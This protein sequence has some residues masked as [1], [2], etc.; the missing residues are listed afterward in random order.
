MEVRHEIIEFDRSC[1]LKL[2]MHKLGDVSRH[3]H[4]SIE[5]LFVLAGEVTVLAGGRQT[6]LTK[7]DVLL[8]N[9]NTAHEL[10]AD[11]CVIIALQI[12]LSKFDL[13]EKLLRELY[14]DC[15]STTASGT[16]DFSRL[17][18]L[19]ANMIQR[20]AAKNDTTIL[21]NRAMAYSLLHE[22]M[23]NFGAE[24][25]AGDPYAR[26]HLER[27]N[28]IIHYIN[29]HYQEQLTLNQ[30]AE[31]QHL[32][33][34]YLSSFFDKY[35]GVNF[36]TYYTNLRLDH[37]MQNLIDSDVP[38]EQ[39]AVNNGFADARAFVRAFKK[40]YGI[41]PSVYRRNI[42]PTT[43]QTEK[44]PLLAINYLDF[45]PENYLHVLSQYMEN[46]VRGSAAAPQREATSLDLGEISAA[47]PVRARLRHKWRTFIG[48]GRARELLYADV[49]QML[50]Q[51]QRDIGFRY[52]RFH[53]IF[54]DDM[55][56]CKKEK[57]GVLRF[58][59]T[60]IDKV[61]DFIR[62]VGLRP[63]IQFS[64]MPR[65]LAENPSHQ[66]YDSPFIIS[67][68]AR[69][70]E[71]K[72]LVRSFLEHVRARYGAAEMRNWLFS[73]WNEPDT[74]TYLFG[75]GTP[76][77]YYALYEATYRT[78]KEFDPVLIFGTPSLFPI[79]DESL[80]WVRNYLD[81]ARRSQC[82][83]QFLDVHYYSDNFRT[84]N[85]QNA[86][87]TAPTSLSGDPEHFGKFLSTIRSFLASELPEA[88]PLYVTEW[89][90]TVSHRN[91][92]NDT[93]F[94]A[95]YL[96]KNFLEN[97]D[98]ADAV[99]YWSLT[100]FLEE[101]QLEEELFHGGMGLFTWNG[102]KKPP[103]HA[104]V[105]LARLGSQLVASGAGYFITREGQEYRAVLYNYEHC[106]PLFT[107]EGFGLTRT[108]RDGVFPLRRYLDV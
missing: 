32:S 30:L 100:D 48:V 94:K 64:F 33:T 5:L 3:W 39:L 78:V 65:A 77:R 62:S 89:N 27:L 19:I 90:L 37:A 28:S 97:Y 60:L 69:M 34:P 101:S 45:K 56:V 75:L 9:S 99:G 31:Q 76:E 15:D 71:W 41:I 84:V 10:H 98:R 68:P 21:S 104:M 92:I 91:L 59:F 43:A 87:F 18:Q 53:G 17:K 44:D 38:V 22:L 79:S 47:A 24:K 50:T 83:P 105:M 63:L 103:Y 52:V 20:N 1:P 2:F 95:C 36:S 7:D 74:S 11:E 8:I 42:A 66:V 51:L 16:K 80:A 58:S 25:P 106:N 96:A 13:P 40:K 82:V 81:F 86:A 55:L 29:A 93:C 70:D 35:M 6:V 88:T 46:A 57:E 85:H 72:L 14:F 54:S 12:K 67:A 102:I 107:E 61:L 26:K 49:Q 73:V 4:D 108:N 23:E